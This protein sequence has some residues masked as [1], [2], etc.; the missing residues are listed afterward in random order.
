MGKKKTRVLLISLALALVIAVGITAQPVLIP[1]FNSLRATAALPAATET[2]TPIAIAPQVTDPADSPTT[3]AAAPTAAPICLYDP[4]VAAMLNDLDPDTWASWIRLLSGEQSVELNGETYTIETR[5][6]ENLFNGDPDARA[7]EFVADQLRLWD[8]EDGVTLFE[9]TYTPDLDDGTTPEWKNLVAVLPGSDPA[10]AGQEVLL[11]AHLDSITGSDPTEIAPGADDNAT[12][13]AT[14]LEAARVFKDRSFK[15]TIRIVFFTGEELGLHGSRAYV[16]QHTG[17]LGSILGVIN[18]DMFGY[19]ADDDRCFEIHAGQLKES[20]LV[21]GCLVDLLDVYALDL[22]FDYLTHEAIS[23]SDHSSFWR[24][25]VGAI[26]VLENFSTHNF[27]NGCRGTDR[28]PNYHTEGD[29]V[30]ALN[31]DTAHAIARA[32]I[33]TA[34]T[35]A[36]PAGN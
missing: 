4:R 23:A 5:F 11:T 21:G 13:V 36:E 9:E 28:N 32:A 16:A 33:L 19:D 15:H 25:G 31:L 6:T 26:E 35:L 12:G 1:W 34:A 7:F 29:R 17:E 22:K 24:E 8:Y 2:A 18:L 30:S 14:L 27:E 20:N 3:L 10:P